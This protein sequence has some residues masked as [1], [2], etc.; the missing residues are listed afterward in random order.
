MREI[1]RNNP[2]KFPDHGAL[3]FV[4]KKCGECATIEPEMIGLSKRILYKLKDPG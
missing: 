2:E 4:I 1:Y 3:L